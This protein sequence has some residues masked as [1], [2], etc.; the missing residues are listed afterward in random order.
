MLGEQ[1]W[2]RW[3]QRRGAGSVQLF[4][5]GWV[6][7]RVD[8]GDESRVSS[9]SGGRCRLRASLWMSTTLH[10]EDAS[11]VVLA[12]LGSA[13]GTSGDSIDWSAVVG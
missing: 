11:A 6:E 5:Q 2:T 10:R 12:V 9:T 13:P 4:I 8:L 7:S 1:A 3:C